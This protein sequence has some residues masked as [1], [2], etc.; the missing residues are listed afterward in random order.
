MK[1]LITL[2]IVLAVAIP[3]VV[4]AQTPDYYG[5]E[6]PDLSTLISWIEDGINT[7]YVRFDT[8]AHKNEYLALIGNLYTAG[9]VSNWSQCAM[10]C[11]MLKQ[12]SVNI[13]GTS[14]RTSAETVCEVAG[15][16][17]T[18]PSV[19]LLTPEQEYDMQATFVQPPTGEIMRARTK[20]VKHIEYA[21]DPDACY[22][23]QDKH[24]QWH[25]IGVCDKIKKVLI[26]NG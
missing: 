26:D 19:L 14:H 13:T 1:R 2:A 20:I 22:L 17:Y 21:G 24:G 15:W 6:N 12:A 18:D 3:A 16:S 4:A 23:W 9:S 5:Y 8:E 10:I 25:H 7:G 11:A